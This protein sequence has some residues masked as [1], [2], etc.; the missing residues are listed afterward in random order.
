[1]KLSANTKITSCLTPSNPNARP[2]TLEWDPSPGELVTQTAGDG[3]LEEWTPRGTFH[4]DDLGNRG[5]LLHVH[6]DPG[7]DVGEPKGDFRVVAGT[8][9]R[10]CRP[11]I[12]VDVRGRIG[13]AN[14]RWKREPYPEWTAWIAGWSDCECPGYANDMGQDYGCS[15]WIGGDLEWLQD[16]SGADDKIY[17]LQIST[18]RGDLTITRDGGDPI[19]VYTARESQT[20]TSNIT[21]TLTDTGNFI[22]LSNGTQVLWQSY[23]HPTDTLLS[24]MNYQQTPRSLH[25]SRRLILRPA[26][27]LWSGIRAKASWSLDGVG[28]PTGGADAS[29]IITTTIWGMSRILSISISALILTTSNYNLTSQGDYF[30][31]TV[32]QVEGR[33]VGQPEAFAMVTTLV[34]IYTTKVERTSDSNASLSLSDCR[35]A[36]WKWSDCE[37]AGYANYIG[38]DSGCSYWIGRDLEWV[39]NSAAKAKSYIGIIL[40]VVSAV[41]LLMLAVVVLI[42]RNRKVKR[43]EELHELLTMEGY[44]GS[45]ELDNNGH[46]L[47]LFTYSSV[48]SATDNFSSNNKLGEGGFGP[49]YKGRTGE[50]QDIAVKLLSRKSGQGLLEFKNELILIS[51]LQHVNLVKLISDFGLARIF[52]EA[53]SEVNTNRRVG[54]YGYMAP[55]YAMQG[56]FS[57]K[58]D[59]YSYGVLVLEIVSGRRNG[60]FHEIEGPL[61]IVE[62]VSFV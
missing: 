57:V 36:C 38:R 54:T 25:G 19:Q 28:W 18:K 16:N 35:D 33:T 43:E 1:M 55:E 9:Q 59:V 7:R 60:S 32:I 40:G 11:S 41:V 6:S 45:Y 15:Y 22:L 56:I 20:T 17:V 52:K 2:F 29:W 58:S 31:Y 24:G 4:D 51:E 46:Q 12:R 53:A 30:M 50:G 39:Q 34:M 10:T 13:Y 49:V 5:R 27:S 47:K 26:L 14:Y 48:I 42:M 8:I 44:T 21:A 37:C 3:V 61:S 23:D 62:Y